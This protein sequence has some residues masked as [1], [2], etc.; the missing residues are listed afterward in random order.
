MAKRKLFSVLL[1][2]A[3]LAQICFCHNKAA[4][5]QVQQALAQDSQ[6]SSQT[7]LEPDYVYQKQRLEQDIAE[8]KRTLLGQLEEYSQQERKYNI[9]VNQYKTLK[10]LKS[11]EDAVG[12]AR[13]AML[14]RNQVLE[15][16]LNLLRLK[17]INSQGIELAEKQKARE[18]LERDINDLREFTQRVEPVNDRVQLNQLADEFLSLG[19]RIQETAAYASSLLEIG[20]MQAIH[21]K[22]VVIADRIETKQ[23]TTSSALTKARNRPALKETERLMTDIKQRL[24][25][26]WLDLAEVDES[27]DKA[28]RIFYKYLADDLSPIYSRLAQLIS[29]FEELLK[30]DK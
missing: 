24:D 23:A 7:N 11:I 28:Y 4:S 25:E 16:Y 17:L 29:Y 14:L 18:W 3:A 27:R 30:N 12:A 20:Q 5:C 21:D 13:E 19:G 1:L 10:T 15:T 26:V 8:L 9:A 6:N 2:M 22:A